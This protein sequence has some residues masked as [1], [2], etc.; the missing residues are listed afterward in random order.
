LN[1]T[2]QSDDR[3]L[4]VNSPL[5]NRSRR[6]TFVVKKDKNDNNQEESLRSFIPSCVTTRRNKCP[7]N[8]FFNTSFASQMMIPSDFVDKCDVSIQT[9]SEM[10]DFGVQSCASCMIE[11]AIQTDSNGGNNQN[12]ANPTSSLSSCFYTDMDKSYL[13]EHRKMCKTVQEEVETLQFKY[14]EAVIL[15]KEKELED[16]V[17]NDQLERLQR[18]NQM[19]KE[20]IED[21]TA[22]LNE[23]D[24][25]LEAL[26]EKYINLE[27]AAIEMES[28]FQQS[29]KIK[30]DELFKA[31]EDKNILEEK[32][33][34]IL[35]QHEN[36]LKVKDSENNKLRKEIANLDDNLR[37]LSERFDSSV[38]E[39][40]TIIEENKALK[41]HVN[42][43]MM[44]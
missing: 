34:N 30:V 20:C 26:N 25:T 15:A 10:V 24:G 36:E 2:L 37:E 3:E 18:E 21:L 31:Q 5:F 14:D 33:D 7:S 42:K 41:L 11:T 12:E 38:K 23:R 40:N 35:I 29:Y 43:C 32:L 13:C 16:K 6:K 1:T 8:S 39:I 28:Q 17:S 9:G 27:E 19:L 4:F 44:Y 22:K